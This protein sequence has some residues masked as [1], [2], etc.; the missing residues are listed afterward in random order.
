MSW[1]RW[2]HDHT[3]NIL[4]FMT[5][6]QRGDTVLPYH[7]ARMPNIEAFREQGVTFSQA[8]C[9]SPHCWP[10]R[11]AFF[12]GLYPSEHGV[13]NNVAVQN[14]LSR[15]L[16]D[17]VR[18]WT[19]DFAAAGY[20]L[21]WTGKWHVSYDEG[22]ADRG[23]DVHSLSAGPED[24]RASALDRTWEAYRRIAA[25]ETPDGASHSSGE[26]VRPGYGSYTH[27]GV[28]ENPFGDEDHVDAAIEALKQSGRRD[29]PWMM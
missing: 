10:A 7:P 21:H 26:I 18:L 24:R 3:G 9:P 14:T 19:E 29:V 8:F 4:V 6:Q 12:T 20:D 17:G 11:A 27:Y 23:F 15:G 5:D 1:Q 28:R 16:N 25:N 13:W 22:P 2:G